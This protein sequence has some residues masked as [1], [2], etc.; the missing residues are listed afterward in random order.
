M[1]FGSIY[2][3]ERSAHR[4][5]CFTIKYFECMSVIFLVHTI[6]NVCECSHKITLVWHIF[7]GAFERIS[8]IILIK[9]C[10]GPYCIHNNFIIPIS[11]NQWCEHCIYCVNWALM[12]IFNKFKRKLICILLFVL[13]TFIIISE[14][15]IW[16]RPLNKCFFLS[17]FDVRNI[18]FATLFWFNVITPQKTS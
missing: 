8:A 11:F 16:K 3:G 12:T 9:L 14:W 10:S 2:T 13:T 18:F 4:R 15:F 17:I 1:D 6:L 7:I 5:V